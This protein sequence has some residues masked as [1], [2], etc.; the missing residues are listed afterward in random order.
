MTEGKDKVKM[1]YAIRTMMIRENSYQQRYKISSKIYE[2]II[3]ET[4]AVIGKSQTG[5]NN[6]YYGR[7]HS[8]EVRTL[9][10]EKR[11]IQDPPM[12]GKT[13]SE[14]TKSKLQIANQKQ[15]EDPQQIELRKKITKE[16]MKDPE[17]RYKAGNG[18][19]GKSWYHNPETKECSTFFP[20][21][22]PA[23]YIKGRI[24]KK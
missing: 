18:K 15:F 17:S 13:H 8:D 24:I 12:L 10:K 1:S 3:K 20:D 6:P 23:G 9:M 11:K 16:Q 5:E 7:T 22:V 14:K 21:N 2:S 19:R 4:K